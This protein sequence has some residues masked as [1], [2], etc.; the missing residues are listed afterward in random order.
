MRFQFLFIGLF[1]FFGCA[2]L[3]PAAF[4]PDRILSDP[5]A[6]WVRIASESSLPGYENGK[7]FLEIV[8]AEK[9]APTLSF[10]AAELGRY[11]KL[12]LGMDIPITAVP[13][14]GRTSLVL[15]DNQWSRAAGLTVAEMPL[16]GFFLKSQGS[17]IFLGGIDD[18]AADPSNPGNGDLFFPHGTLT[19]VYDFLERFLG[20]RF[21]FPGEMGTIIPQIASLSFP[22]ME[23]LERPDLP[24]RIFAIPA[25]LQFPEQVLNAEER[26]RYHF[27][28]R[29]AAFRIPEKGGLASLALPQRWAA[30][31]PEIL[32]ADESGQ[33]ILPIAPP[34]KANFCFS[35]QFLRDKL[36]Q[37]AEAFLTGQ[38]AST[39]GLENWNPA[40]FQT[41][42]FNLS[43]ADG[44]PPC[45]CSHCQIF[46]QSHPESERFWTFIAEVASTLQKKGIPGYLTLCSDGQYANLPQIP[47]PGNVLIAVTAIN[48]WFE[49]NVRPARIEE[50]L[51]FWKKTMKRQALLSASISRACDAPDFLPAIVPESIGNY[52]S[53][54]RNFLSGVYL[55]VQESYGPSLYLNYYLAAKCTWNTAL[56]AEQILQEHHLL[57]FGPGAP[58]MSK[59]FSDSEKLWLNLLQ[60]ESTLPRGRKAA[61]NLWCSIYTPT[62]IEQFR[63]YFKEAETAAVHSPAYRK[64]IAYFRQCFLDPLEKAME[65]PQP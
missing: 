29:N 23:I 61:E 57:M 64:R 40:A 51:V 13:T 14:V 55:Y 24:G 5:P 47:L 60:A 1:L 37:D 56:K 8:I 39:R 19:A 54:N 49:N 27:Q 62:Q 44:V 32:R 31:H 2:L 18:S 48:P 42:F 36:C 52:F 25:N 63:N 15:G 16:D 46:Y 35:S 17:C 6:R 59:F 33:R 58:A 28:L 45:Y 53:R 3:F 30:S 26:I 7:L 11:L 22:E 20:A 65:T 4:S 43:P 34:E 38:A 50:Q 9:A 21:Y 41:G 10:A 12:A